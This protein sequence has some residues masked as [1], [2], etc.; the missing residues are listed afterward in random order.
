MSKELST[1]NKSA[2]IRLVQ[3]NSCLYDVTHADWK[4]ADKKRQLWKD[5]ADKLQL[6]GTLSVIGL[7]DPFK[8]L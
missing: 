2:L 7:W 3:E 5:I 4:N 6:G 8:W 1:E